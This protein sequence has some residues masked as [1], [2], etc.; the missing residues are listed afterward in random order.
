MGV[1]IPCF[2]LEKLTLPRKTTSTASLKDVYDNAFLVAAETTNKNDCV[3]ICAI[4]NHN[5]AGLVSFLPLAMY[6][7]DTIKRVF[8]YIPHLEPPVDRT[9]QSEVKRALKEAS[10]MLMQLSN[11]GALCHVFLVTADSTLDLPRHPSQDRVQLHTVSPEPIFGPRTWTE[12][13]GFHLAYGIYFGDSPIAKQA[14]IQ[15]IELLFKQLRTGYYPGALSDLVLNLIPGDGYAIE[16]ILGDTTYKSLRPGE[17]WSVIIKIRDRRC[18]NAQNI[19][20]NSNRVDALMDELFEM[21]GVSS[22]YKETILSACL[23]YRHSCLPNAA[24]V[25]IERNWDAPQ[26]TQS[27]VSHFGFW[28]MD[29]CGSFIVENS[30]GYQK[31]S[32]QDRAS[33]QEDYQD[34]LDEEINNRTLEHGSPCASDEHKTG[35]GTESSEIPPQNTP[36]NPNL[37]SEISSNPCEILGDATNKGRPKGRE[38]NHRAVKPLGGSVDS[39]VLTPENRKPKEKK[40]EKPAARLLDMEEE[41]IPDMAQHEWHDI[42]WC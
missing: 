35:L 21:L 20:Y 9:R 4:Y 28:G 10:D 17:K 42:G 16:S 13:S 14:Q 8:D 24:T 31:F 12:L 5:E 26:P 15:K 11:R 6:D 36:H 22:A 18:S 2:G 1:F 39:D 3:A 32:G 33:E 34:P 27:D 40:H 7:I 38:R 37:A 25:K 29:V 30:R 23:E 41:G 19:G